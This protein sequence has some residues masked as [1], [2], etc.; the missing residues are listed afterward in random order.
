MFYQPI[1]NINNE[2][3]QIKN[4]NNQHSTAVL[5]MIARPKSRDHLLDR[6]DLVDIYC[7]CKFLFI[8]LLAKWFTMLTNS[9][10]AFRY[11]I[12]IL[13]SYYTQIIVAAECQCTQN[14]GL[15]MT[16]YQYPVTHLIMTSFLY[17]IYA[18][19]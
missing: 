14:C 18:L 9:N 7:K 4:E 6:L 12:I 16:Y 11:F 19:N 13:F 8:I 2:I 5:R 17:R 3:I 1:F 10:A 15:L